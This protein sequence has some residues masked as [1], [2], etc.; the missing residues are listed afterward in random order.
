MEVATGLPKAGTACG[1][2]TAHSAN[3]GVTGA[4]QAG[5]DTSETVRMAG[6]PRDDPAFG[7][8]ATRALLLIE[9]GG[10]TLGI[11]SAKGVGGPELGCPLL[12]RTVWMAPL[13]ATSPV[14]SL[15]LTS[16]TS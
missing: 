1:A 3:A 13:V 2:A 10:L 15:N 5:Q 16:D 14:S 6:A 12:T 4:A 9:A 7:R 11:P 8:A